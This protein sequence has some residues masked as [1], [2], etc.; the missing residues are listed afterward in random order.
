LKSD[1]RAARNHPLPIDSLN[2]VNTRRPISTGDREIVPSYFSC[3]IVERS[4]VRFR[5]LHTQVPLQWFLKAEQS[6]SIK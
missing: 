6:G 5:L 3:V 1:I 2:M 4:K